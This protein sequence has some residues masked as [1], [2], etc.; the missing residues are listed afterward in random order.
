MNIRTELRGHYLAK[1]VVFGLL[2]LLCLAVGPVKRHFAD[3][4][5]YVPEGIHG[6]H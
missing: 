3:Y 5:Q 4:A 1:I 2:A 6:K